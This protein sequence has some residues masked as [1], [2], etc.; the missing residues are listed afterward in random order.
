[1]QCHKYAHGSCAVSHSLSI[2]K[3]NKTVVAALESCV[4]SGVFPLAPRMIPKPDVDY[5]HLIAVELLKLRRVSESYERGIDTLEE[6]AA[7]KKRLSE[8]IE[9]LRRQQ[10]AAC[11]E[12]ESAAVKPEDMRR[13]TLDVLDIIKRPDVTEQ[14]K[15]EAL[16]SILSHI[17]YQKSTNQLQLFFV[18]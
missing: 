6:Y 16:R 13:R 1:M 11:A 5:D 12:S 18:F 7:K 10:A 3:A 15:N 14:A 2:A 8:G 4:L 17:V 9:E